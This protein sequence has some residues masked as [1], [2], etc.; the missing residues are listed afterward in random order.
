MASRLITD[1]NVKVIPLYNDFVRMCRKSGIQILITCT[2]RSLEEQA[3]LWKQGREL[4]NGI[5]RVVDAKKVVTKV[6]PGKSA[7]NVKEN[8][9]PASMAFDFALII[10]GK[11]SW[12][13][14]HPD[15]QL[16]VQH[17]IDCGLKSLRP[18]EYAHLEFPNWQKLVK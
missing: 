13:T 6:L 5:W 15:W 3:S 11:L 18:F 7:H 16:A 1:L 12:D 8:G 9:R 4:K 10:N 14:K 17:G 2:Y